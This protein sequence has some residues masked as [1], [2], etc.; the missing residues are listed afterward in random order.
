MYKIWFEFP[1]D[2]TRKR[3]STITE[4]KG[5]YVLMCKGADSIMFPRCQYDNLSLDEIKNDLQKFAVEGLRT[6]VMSQKELSKEKFEQIQKEIQELKISDASTKEER[7]AK[8]YDDLEQ[9]LEYVGS[10]AIED[11]L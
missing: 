1:F 3:M 2:S 8:Y 11:K 5:K 4:H 7:L 10:S 9:D 6:L